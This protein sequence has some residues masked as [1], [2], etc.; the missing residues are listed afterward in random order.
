M[1][2]ATIEP[3]KGKPRVLVRRFRLSLVP[4]H[5]LLPAWQP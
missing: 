3:L 5:E 2:L 4:S 1:G